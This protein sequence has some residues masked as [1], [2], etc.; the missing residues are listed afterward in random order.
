MKTF[1]AAGALALVSGT[2][3]AQQA[4]SASKVD[5]AKLADIVVDRWQLRSGE[6]AVLFWERTS[7][8]GAAAALRKAIVAKGGVTTRPGPRRSRAPTSP[9]GC[10]RTP[11]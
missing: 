9:S 6:R 5:W 10:R 2:A 3:T 7:D 11:A 8:R 1:V 4:P